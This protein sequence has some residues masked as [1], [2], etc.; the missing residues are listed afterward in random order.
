MS[1]AALKP[2][3]VYLCWEG[4]QGQQPA[5]TVVIPTGETKAFEEI[6]FKHPGWDKPTVIVVRPDFAPTPS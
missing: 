4:E 5:E 1:L 3:T 2:V 6:I